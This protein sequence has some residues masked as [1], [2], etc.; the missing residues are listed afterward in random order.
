MK[1]LEE[2]EHQ[3]TEYE[4]LKGKVDILTVERDKILQ[5]MADVE[6]KRKEV[7]NKTFEQLRDAFKIVFKDL[8]GGE[9][10]LRLEGESLEES[11]LIIE[12]SPA[13]KRLL[14]IDAMSGGEK[15]L[16]AITFLFAIQHI[17]P[18][19]FYIL[20]EVDAAL[21]KP[22]TKKIVELLKQ[23]SKRSQ[24][25]VISHNDMTVSAADCVY[26]ISME[27]GESKLVAIR[28]PETS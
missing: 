28:M 13:G 2:Y 26:G 15:T 9:A 7:F 18:A 27:N 11:G 21:D 25:I 4:E 22:N 23:Y 8:T 24:F 6:I 5:V 12:A 3:R 19:P 14:N 20:D 16:T 17:K 10:D 1:A